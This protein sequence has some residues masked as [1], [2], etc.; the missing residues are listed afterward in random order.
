[1]NP[2]LTLSDDPEPAEGARAARL[3]QEREKPE[4]PFE[5]ALARQ[6]VEIQGNP[7]ATAR[8]AAQVRKAYTPPQKP[9]PSV[10][11][12]AIAA[13][14]RRLEERA[15]DAL[16]RPETDQDKTTEVDRQA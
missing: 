2:T 6:L 9:Y 14:A 5:A 15:L 7:A 8:Q 3:S 16:A 1:M 10:G 12:L 13:R 4:P 11:D